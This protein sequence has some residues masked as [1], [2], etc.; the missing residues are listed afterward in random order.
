M[1][2][3]FYQWLSMLTCVAQSFAIWSSNFS[4]PGISSAFFAIR[5]LE[6]AHFTF[7]AL[8]KALSEAAIET[9]NEIVPAA[10]LWSIPWLYCG[11]VHLRV[12]IFSSG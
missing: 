2:T 11:V 4:R 7:V 3:R 10:V 5:H 12:F 1:W 8:R 9:L 6:A